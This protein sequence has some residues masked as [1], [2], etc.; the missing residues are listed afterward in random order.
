[1]SDYFDPDKENYVS[2]LHSPHASYRLYYHLVW[3]TK[4]RKPALREEIGSRLIEVVTATCEKEGCQLLGIHVEPE[5]VHALIG[6]RPTHNVADVANRIK[7]TT[8]RALRLEF[9]VLSSVVDE[10]SLWADGYCA[11][12]VGD[13]NVAQIKAYL[14]KQKVHHH[15]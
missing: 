12:T 1:M 3:G 4:H 11:H 9:P 15:G 7:G 8:A 5:H 10:G 6:L 13:A 2:T 14:D